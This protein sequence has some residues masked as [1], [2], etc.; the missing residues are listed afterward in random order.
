M[1][2]LH[3]D[4]FVLTTRSVFKT[5]Y[6]LCGQLLLIDLSLSAKVTSLVKVM[7]DGCENTSA[8]SVSIG[9]SSIVEVLTHVN[10]IIFLCLRILSVIYWPLL[11][12]RHVV[13]GCHRSCQFVILI[14]RT[15]VKNR[16]YS[17]V[18]I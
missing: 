11:L 3:A 17:S 14:P 1:S 15:L 7:L 16:I 10:L 8:L 5:T 18:V 6:V 13:P 4:P 9:F 12:D 2:K